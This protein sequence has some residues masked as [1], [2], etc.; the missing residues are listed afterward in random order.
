MKCL[1]KPSQKR[2]CLSRPTTPKHGSGSAWQVYSNTGNALKDSDRE[3]SER[4]VIISQSVAQ[5][6]FQGQTALNRNLRWTDGVMKFIGIS[7]EPRRIIGVVPDFDDENIIPSF[8]G[9]L[10]A[11]RSGRMEW[12][13]VRSRSA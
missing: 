8:H 3:G 10:S 13:L 1:I 12:S 9:D 2:F 6:L 11:D 5:M 7:T 4:V